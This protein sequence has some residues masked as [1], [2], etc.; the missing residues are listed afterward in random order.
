MMSHSLIHLFL[1]L[2]WVVAYTPEI[3]FLLTMVMTKTL[4]GNVHGNEGAVKSG[5][6]PDLPRHMGIQT[7]D[8][9]GH[10]DQGE[11]P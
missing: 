6:S 11:L 7:G 3:L 4:Y 5:W 10:T 9:A 1:P 8:G 2:Q